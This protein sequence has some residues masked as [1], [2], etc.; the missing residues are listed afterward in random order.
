MLAGAGTGKTRALTYRVA[1]MVERGI[2]PRRL[3]LLT[4][5]NKAAREMLSRVEDL[6]GGRVPGI[7]GGTF[8]HVEEL[9]QLGRFASSHG[10]LEGFMGEIA[11]VTQLRGSSAVAPQAPQDPQ[12][13]RVVCS[14]IHQ[15]K[16]L[17]W[18]VVFLPYLIDRQ[19]PN[20]A[21]LFREEELEEERRIF[22]VA[23]T[24]AREQ[25]Y[26]CSPVFS[27]ARDHR[28]DISRESLFLRE[29]S[30]APQLFETW[31]VEEE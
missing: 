9:R 13:E 22:H 19:F 30:Q 14:T 18:R 25:L 28:W 10:S 16:G 11:L 2:D 24:R 27:G 29:L 1:W 21:A 17:E 12:E 23:V 7:W 3:L 5:T 20:S 6:L 15:A 8:H 26:L 4:F 31:E